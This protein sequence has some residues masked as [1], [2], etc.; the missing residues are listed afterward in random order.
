MWVLWKPVSSPIFLILDADPTANIRNTERIHRVMLGG[1]LYDPLTMNEAETGTRKRQ[2][3]WWEAEKTL[4][5]RQIPAAGR[6]FV[7]RGLQD[8]R[9]AARGVSSQRGELAEWSKASHSKCEVP[10]TVPRVRIPHSPP[11]FYIFDHSKPPR[12]R[13]GAAARS[14]T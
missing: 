13:T 2:P 10:A 12:C 5:E 3:Y 7:T 11:F 9:T 4:I 8:V 1:R 6:N 14:V